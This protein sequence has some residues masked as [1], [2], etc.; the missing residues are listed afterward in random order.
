MEAVFFTMRLNF[1]GLLFFIQNNRHTCA[2]EHVK[3]V[4]ATSIS[5]IVFNNITIL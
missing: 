2:S 3:H 4:I 1:V 5:I